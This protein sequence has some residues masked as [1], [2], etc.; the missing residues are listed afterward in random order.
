MLPDTTTETSCVF[1]NTMMTMDADL[2]IVGVGA[3]GKFFWHLKFLKWAISINIIR[4]AKILS[5]FCPPVSAGQYYS[6][7]HPLILSS[8]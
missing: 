6:H 2:G 3:G 7:P 4:Y 1:M 5:I 8:H